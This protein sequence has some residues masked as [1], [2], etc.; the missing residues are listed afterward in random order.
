VDLLAGYVRGMDVLDLGCRGYG[1]S[2]ASNSL[3]HALHGVARSYLGADVEVSSGPSA[4][5]DQPVVHLDVSEGAQAAMRA[6]HGRAFDA[7]VAG[8]ILEHL[9]RPDTL[10]EVAD[11][12]LRPTGILVLSTPNPYAPH[13]AYRGLRRDTWE[14]ADHVLY[15]FPSGLAELADRCGFTLASWTTVGWTSRRARLRESVL[16]LVRRISG[17]PVAALPVSYLPLFQLL[18][19]LRRWHLR[20]IGETMVCRFTRRA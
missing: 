1:A 3:A 2:G 10:F 17:T 5:R 18:P 8:E 13:R 6:L 11:V 20:P 7:V 16:G 15:G 12:A 19:L 9:A 4:A 14:S